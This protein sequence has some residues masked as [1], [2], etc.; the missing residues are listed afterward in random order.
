[1]KNRLYLDTNVML[2][3]LGERK[4]FYDAIARIVSFADI[5]KFKLLVSTLSYSTVYYLLT[6]FE[7]HMVVIEKL[8]KFKILTE[9]ADLSDEIIDKGLVS[10]FSDFEDAL[11]YYCALDAGCDII[12]TRN[13][14]DFKHSSIPVLTPDQFIKTI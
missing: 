13:L 7:S 11:Q 4:P 3:L 1:M 14:K 6:K 5:G 8:R 9:S 2:D 12:L 10:D